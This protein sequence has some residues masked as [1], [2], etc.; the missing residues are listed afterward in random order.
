VQQGPGK[1]QASQGS[2]QQGSGS[3]HHPNQAATK[4]ARS[5]SGGLQ[6][7]LGDSPSSGS[8][9]AA[10]I[11]PIGVTRTHHTNRSDPHLHY[12]VQVEH[13]L[14]PAMPGCLRGTRSQGLI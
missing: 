12:H 10:Y 7:G 6:G 2:K 9:A 14:V 13:L 1:Q 3:H 4:A 5:S 8:I 11:T